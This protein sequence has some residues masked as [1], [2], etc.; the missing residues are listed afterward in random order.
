[1]IG[2]FRQTLKQVQGDVIEEGGTNTPSRGQA[3]G[4]GLGLLIKPSPTGQVSCTL[5][6]ST[7]QVWSTKKPSR[8][9]ERLSNNF[10]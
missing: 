3:L 6:F 9:S 8:N 4:W 5:A 10:Y 2:Y 1:V 7:C